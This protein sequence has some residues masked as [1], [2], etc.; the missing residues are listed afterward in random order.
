MSNMYKD[1]VKQ[2]NYVVGCEFDC[3]YCQRSFQAQ[4]KR[5]KHNCKK[6]YFYEPHFHEERLSQY[7]PLTDGEDEFIWVNSSSD[8]YFAKKVW[9]TKILENL[10]RRYPERTFLFQSKE[11]LIFEKYDFLDNWVLCTTIESNR[12][13]P[14]IS[15]APKQ[16]WRINSFKELDHPRK[17]VTIEPILRF[18]YSEFLEIL[19]EIN[20]ERIYIG[21]DSKSCGLP[22]PEPS[23]VINFIEDLKKFTKVKTKYIKEVEA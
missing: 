21:F 17:F 19:R 4:M 10:K 20:P 12:D 16:S 23:K 7:L 5:Q 15:N 14:E 18:D 3:V 22:E 9:M 13:Y 2:I 11:P 1:S 8:I 6:C